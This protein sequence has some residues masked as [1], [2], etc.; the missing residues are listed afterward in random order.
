MPG[1]MVYAP[2]GWFA[3]ALLSLVSIPTVL[4]IM[5]FSAG[6]EV[7]DMVAFGP[8][9]NNPDPKAPDPIL[10]AKAQNQPLLVQIYPEAALFIP[11]TIPHDSPPAFLLAANDDPR[12]SIS[13]MKLLEAYREAKVPMVEAHLFTHKAHMALIWVN[14]VQSKLKSINTW[15]Q[16]LADWLSDNNIGAVKGRPTSVKPPSHIE[17]E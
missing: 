14:T 1:R 10:T 6:G 11:D 12:C 13:L 5:G 16:R 8:N 2:C 17:A 15:P 4:G 7:V 3:A 9:N